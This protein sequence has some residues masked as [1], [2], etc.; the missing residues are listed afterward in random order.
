M[1]PG[2]RGRGSPEKDFTTS[3]G[4]HASEE[5]MR[6]GSKQS[7]TETLGEGRIYLGPFN[8]CLFCSQWYPQHLAGTVVRQARHPGHQM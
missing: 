6:L 5:D 1:G 8:L 2:Q 7:P 4:W 3:L